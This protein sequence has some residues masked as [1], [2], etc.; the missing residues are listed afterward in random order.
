MAITTPT[1][2]SEN[3]QLKDNEKQSC[4]HHRRN[5]SWSPADEGMFFFTKKHQL[6]NVERMIE[7]G[8]LY[9]ATSNETVNSSSTITVNKIFAGYH[10]IYH[11]IDDRDHLIMRDDA[12]ERPSRCHLNHTIR[13]SISRSAT[14]TQYALPAMMQ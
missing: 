2:S 6:I 1:L 8:N 11:P 7:W 12:T 10:G 4:C 14:T 9:F 5:C 13:S 3:W